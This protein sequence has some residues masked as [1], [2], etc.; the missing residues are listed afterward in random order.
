ML[1]YILETKDSAKGKWRAS[2]TMHPSSDRE[3]VINIARDLDDHGNCVRVRS[4]GHA[5]GMDRTEFC[6]ISRGNQ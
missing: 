6:S 2:R 1:R 4:T 5:D 3:R